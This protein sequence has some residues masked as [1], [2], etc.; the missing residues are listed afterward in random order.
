M[1]KTNKTRNTDENYS[2]YWKSELKGITNVYPASDTYRFDETPKPV[3]PKPADNFVIVKPE[4]T[5]EVS[6]IMRL[7]F[8]NSIPV[9]VRGGGTGLSGGAIPI[10]E[11]IVLSTEKLKGLEIDV[12]NR[13]AICDAG[14]TL[15]ELENAAEKHDLSFLPHP[16]A[17]TATVGGMIATNAGGIRALKY[18]TMRNYVLGIQAVLPDGRVIELGSRTIKNSTGY[19][20]LH[21]M[22]GSEG[23]LC[24]ITKAFI[25]LL[26]KLKDMVTLAIPFKDLDKALDCVSEILS[27]GILPLAVEFMERRA[28]EIGEAVSGKKWV[29]QEGEAHL[30]IILEN[31]TEM[32]RV[33]E[34]SYSLGAID[35]FVALSRR[36][37]K[38][39]L[40]I[41][42]R[43]YDGLKDQIIEILDVCVPP[44]NVAEYVRLSNEIAERYGIDVITYGHAGDGNV[45]QHPLLFDG[46]QNVYFK[47]REELLEL[48]R[49]LGGVI[50][51]EH[52]IGTVKRLEM[53]KL[54]PEQVEL[55][56]SIKKIFDPKNILNPDKVV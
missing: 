8:E 1:S 30:L 16:G 51:G 46:W 23:T 17:E 6:K 37:Q 10:R 20:L 38:T 9:F 50:S 45:H 11:G 12:K 34:L 40:E 29:T 54:M 41:R 42:S 39:L 43:I 14:V 15:Q 44:G 27:A 49:N 31:K 26:P 21:L 32:N 7:A 25:R 47:F 19:S 55:M 18:G 13:L 4:T 5:Q 56:R 36:E 35:V 33:A 52:G 22:I 24:V 28:V 3:M 48:A 53:E 2:N